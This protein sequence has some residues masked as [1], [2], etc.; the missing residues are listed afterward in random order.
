MTYEGQF[1]GLDIA[2]T[3]GHTACGHACSV[4]QGRETSF[5]GQRSA[6][7]QAAKNPAPFPEIILFLR[8]KISLPSQ[9]S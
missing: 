2:A 1:S 7:F 5:I 6:L 4:W 9:Q 8:G 3:P